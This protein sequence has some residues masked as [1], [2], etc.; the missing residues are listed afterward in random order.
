M[1]P[2]YFIDNWTAGRIW[3]RRNCD[4]STNP[5]PNSCLDGGLLGISANLSSVSPIMQDATEGFSATR[6][7]EPV[8][9][10]D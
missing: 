7:L 5:G 2:D 1:S 4:F 3:G 6:I 10:M 8:S 9:V